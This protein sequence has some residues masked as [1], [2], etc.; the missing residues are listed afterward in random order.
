MS[1]HIPGFKSSQTSFLEAKHLGGQA[2]I[3]EML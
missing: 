2:C 1:K 3:L